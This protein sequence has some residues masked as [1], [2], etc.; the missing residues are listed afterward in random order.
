[1]Q[2][3]QI[4]L[5]AILKNDR[6][7]VGIT[8]EDLNR[9]NIL[10][11][12]SA[13]AIGLSLLLQHEAVL[14]LL[15]DCTSHFFSPLDQALLQSKFLCNATDQWTLCHECDC[16]VAV[17]LLLEADCSVTVGNHRPYFLTNCSL[18]SRRLFFEHLRNR[19]ERLRDISLAIL[20][21]WILNLYRITADSL[22]DYTAKYLWAE[23]KEQ[24]DELHQRKVELSDGLKPYYSDNFSIRAGLFTYPHHAQVAELALANGFRPVDECGQPILLWQMWPTT[25]TN[26]LEDD[27]G[28]VNWLLQHDLRVDFIMGVFHL[29]AIHRLADLVGSRISQLYSENGV[30]PC[31]SSHELKSFL[32]RISCSK[33]QSNL[34]CPCISGS[35]TDLWLVS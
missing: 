9:R 22:P 30:V 29:S 5:E 34:P 3:D 6:L 2:K 27:V 12:S 32:S 19:R 24:A 20:P 16:F 13:W 25:N 4:K 8:L 14:P 28:Y 10:H 33:L 21:H 35:L 1:M 17:K 23:L 11:V 18:M 7:A 15:N 26:T 31:P